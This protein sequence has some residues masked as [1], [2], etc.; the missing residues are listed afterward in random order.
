MKNLASNIGVKLVCSRR[1]L[2]F[3]KFSESQFAVE[4]TL[5]TE[6]AAMVAPVG[7]VFL[8]P[9][10]EISWGNGGRRVS[11]RPSQYE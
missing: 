1:S 7:Q 2:C 4:V 3:L 9:M 10:E 11:K 6:K 8:R 5:G